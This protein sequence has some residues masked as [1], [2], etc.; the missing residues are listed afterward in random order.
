MDVYE[1]KVVT[2]LSFLY[3]LKLQEMHQGRFGFLKFRL[4][5]ITYSL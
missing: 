1:I 3:L 2:S 5:F 4:I